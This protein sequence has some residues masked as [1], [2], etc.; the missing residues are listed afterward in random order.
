MLKINNITLIK[1]KLIYFITSIYILSFFFE[2]YFK[3]EIEFTRFS[4]VEIIF[5]IIFVT[6]LLIYKLNFIKFI[7][8]FDRKNIFEIIIYTILILK[9]IKYLPNFQNYYN[10]YELIIWIYMLCIYIVFKFYLLTD[11]NFIYHIENSFIGVSLIIS[12][13]ILYSFVL[14]KL[15]Y[16]SNGFWAIKDS[17]YY[18]YVG[19]SSINFKSIFS[20]YNQA[21]HLVALGF[22]FLVNRFKSK[23]FV[24]LLIIFYLVIM[25]LIKAKFLIVFFG[26]LM[27][28]LIAK[29]LNLQNIKLTKVFLVLSIIGLSIFYFTVTHFIVV[30]K[31]IINS[32]NFDL[33]KHY[34]FTNF[35]ISLNNYDVYGSLFLKTKYTAIE[36]ANSYNFIL[37]ESSNYF[38]HKIVLK[39]FEFYTDPHSDYFGALANY[40]I[41]GFLIFLGFPIYVVLEYLKNFNLKKSYKDSLIL[42]LIIIM[43]FIEAIITDLFHTQF[44]WIIFAMYLFSLNLKNNK[45]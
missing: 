28:Y 11:K 21:A 24:T 10:L 16:E 45:I 38:N 4:I 23:L 32:S 8:K 25:Y 41:I 37:F 42:F 35:V 30:E 29:N 19:T 12:T 27:I 9:I 26:I 31:G 22:M 14:Y 6:T 13:H 40:G 5:I 1:K 33:F 18:P 2:H 34:Y 3:L 44:V 39:N 36:L 7:F 43:I 17:T 15:G 20:D